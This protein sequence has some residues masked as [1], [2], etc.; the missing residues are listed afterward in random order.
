MSDTTLPSS[1][2]LYVIEQIIVTFELITVSL[3]ISANVFAAASV[4]YIS[5]ILLPKSSSDFL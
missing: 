1:S 5:S 2:I 3:M 4:R